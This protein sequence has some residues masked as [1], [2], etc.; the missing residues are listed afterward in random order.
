[1]HVPGSKSISCRAIVLAAIAQGRSS[2]SGVLRA[3][4]TDMLLAAMTTLG[5]S[6][7]GEGSEIAVTGGQPLVST[8]PRIDLGHGGTPARFMLSVATLVDG[9]VVIDGSSRLR[10]RPMG[11]M[12]ELLA[13]LGV[14]VEA[15]NGSGRLPLRV[16][17]GPWN[18]NCLRVG[19]MASSQFLSALLLVAPRMPG[20]VVIQLEAQA[21]SEPYLQLTIDELQE[22]GLNPSVQYEGDRIARITVMAAAIRP[23]DRVIPADASSALFWAAAAAVIPGSQLLIPRLQLDDG[24]PDAAAFGVLRGMGLEIERGEGGVRLVG[25]SRLSAVGTIDCSGMPD[26]APALAVVGCFAEGETRLTG[27]HTLRHKESDRVRTIAGEL[28]R[29][30]AD[31]VIEGDDLVIRPV[32]LPDTPVTIQTWDDH[33]IAM[34][35][36]VLG[37]RRGGISVSDPGCVAKSYPGFWNDLARLY[38]EARSGDTA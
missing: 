12:V 21:T 24:Q 38:G 32:P 22:W 7:Q 36:A 19:A 34:A 26:A 6:V 35:L 25:P 18:A 14:T 4:D 8:K 17:G 15:V 2:L 11:D 20:G 10:A 27:L 23:H 28:G 16:V 29:A 3:D 30:G 1:M 31:V 37:L 13:S 5:V 9:E 33:R